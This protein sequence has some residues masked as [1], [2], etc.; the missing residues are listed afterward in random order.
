MEI[1]SWILVGLIAGT[2]AKVFMQRPDPGGVTVT[3]VV[4]IAGAVVG[5]FLGAM[6][7]FAGVANFDS[8]TLLLV[9]G[10]AVALL[11]GYRQSIKYATK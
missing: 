8:R 2:F 10:G 4:G 6:L 7:G 9:V 11:M 3:I 5:G 1:L